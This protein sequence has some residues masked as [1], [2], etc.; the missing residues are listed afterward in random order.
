MNVRKQSIARVA[1]LVPVT[2]YGMLVA[3]ACYTWVTVGNW[4]SYGNP[5][6]KDLPHSFVNVAAVTATLVGIA[7][8]LLLPIAELA[9]MALRAF[10]KKE[11]RPHGIR[12][13]LFFTV[14]AALWIADFVR[15]RVGGGGLVEWIFD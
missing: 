9:F 6:P 13:V 15:F 3:A 2:C 8:V 1:A 14:G 7:S 10:L 12:V 11:W 5:D 4:P